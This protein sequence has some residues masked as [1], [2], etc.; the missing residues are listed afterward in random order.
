MRV[1]LCFSGLPR[2]VRET[3]P[4]WKACLLD[5]Y[6]PDVFI[7]SW[8]V[9]PSVRAQ[10]LDLYNPCV[11]QEETQRQFDVTNY[12][13]RIWPH[14]TTPST[15]ISQFYSL[16]QAHALRRNW[17]DHCGFRYDVVVR[18]R[19]DWYL[20]QVDFEINNQV[21]VPRTP[22][23]DGHRFAYCGEPLVGISDQF[24][25]G[26]S[27][28]MHTYAQLVDNVSHLY[29]NCGVDFCG[30]LFLKAHL[31]HHGLKVKQHVWNHGIVRD[32]GVMP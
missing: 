1:A 30:E 8:R 6:K 27:D 4:Y 14:R 12:T 23:L 2:F 16:Q 26:S 29:H 17:E 28:V 9:D 3:F 24:A 13:D 20:K 21:N 22:T 19:F 10:I 25:Y 11:F 7:H 15:V 31:H 5:P 32:W 18:A